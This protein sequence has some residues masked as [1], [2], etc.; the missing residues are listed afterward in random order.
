MLVKMDKKGFTKS[1]YSCDRCH[2]EINTET[3]NRFKVTVNKNNKKIKHWDLCIRCYS[4]LYRGLE[5]GVNNSE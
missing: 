1:I 4:A 3:D 5:K 2:K